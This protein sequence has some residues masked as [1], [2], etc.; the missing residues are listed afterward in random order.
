MDGVSG[1]RTKLPTWRGLTTNANRPLDCEGVEAPRRGFPMVG[2]RIDHY[3][4]GWQRKALGCVE[5]GATLLAVADEELDAVRTAAEER[6]LPLRVEQ[7]AE[8]SNVI[9]TAGEVRFEDPDGV[10]EG[11]R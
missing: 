4:R 3:A 2:I 6:D 8:G 7:R 11:G 5:A 1:V 10:G 9:P